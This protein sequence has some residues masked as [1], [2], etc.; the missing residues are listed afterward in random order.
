MTVAGD[1]E[2]NKDSPEKTMSLL[3]HLAELRRRVIISAL[4]VLAGSVVTFVVNP[5]ILDFLMRP[6]RAIE[7]PGAAG[8]MLYMQTLFEGFLTRLKLSILTGVILSLPVHVFN[9]VR[10]TFPALSG[11]E[12]RIVAVAAG[13]S[14][15]LALAAFSYSYFNII[16]LSVSF[17]TGAGFVPEDVGLLLNYSTNIF[18]VLQFLLICVLLFQ[19]PIVLI[20]LMALGTFSRRTLWRSMRYIV[21]GT[22]LLAAILTP[23]D[24]VSQISVAVPLVVLF[25]GAGV[26]AKILR[27][28]EE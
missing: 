27:L 28:G 24:F 23:P 6:L 18:Y 13:G 17:L 10:F 19:L 9:V 21:A 11:R 2:R 4:A 14:F 1:R 26:L 5:L 15:V 22:F 7:Q 12:K 8:E 20:A 3:D 25:L 16:P